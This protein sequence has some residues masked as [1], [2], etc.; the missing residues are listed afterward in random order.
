VSAAPDEAARLTLPSK[1]RVAVDR[2]G[3]AV[4]LFTSSW[5]LEYAEKENP[6]VRFAF[7]HE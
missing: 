2:H 3:N 6:A 4:V 1:S 5:E 7:A